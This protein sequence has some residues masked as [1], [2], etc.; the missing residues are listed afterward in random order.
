MDTFWQA[1]L[2]VNKKE[3]K[4]PET[5]WSNV[6]IKALRF[7]WSTWYDNYNHFKLADRY[8]NDSDGC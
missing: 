8:K 3:H 2:N 7:F 4:T 6:L 5:F 1:I